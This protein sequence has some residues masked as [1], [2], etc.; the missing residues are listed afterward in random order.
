[1]ER[2]RGTLVERYNIPSLTQ[3][4]CSPKGIPASIAPK[5]EEPMAGK[6]PAGEN[7]I[8]LDIGDME[9]VAQGAALHPA[10]AIPP[11]KRVEEP[12][13]ASELDLAREAGLSPK[14]PPKQPERRSKDAPILPDARGELAVEVDA[15]SADA[16]SVQPVAVG[17]PEPSIVLD[18]SQFDKGPSEGREASPDVKD[19]LAELKKPLPVD[20]ELV[21][22]QELSDMSRNMDVSAFLPIIVG[23]VTDENP[24]IRALA[25][26]T[27]GHMAKNK[28][29]IPSAIGPLCDALSDGDSTVRFN[30]SFALFYAKENGDSIP[31]KLHMLLYRPLEPGENSVKR[32][33][34]E[35]RRIHA[36][37]TSHAA[38]LF[39]QSKE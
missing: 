4:F 34:D 15:G 30:A 2:K 11:A 26:K 27:L 29:R 23:G 37:R 16:G 28:V 19:A 13:E 6:G 36:A 25:T 12:Q 5:T 10:N 18:M 8:E 7:T 24:V 21:V 1:M 14:E 9:E 35:V 31:E 39:K 33:M 38:A 20:S 22:F 17:R 3:R 32:S